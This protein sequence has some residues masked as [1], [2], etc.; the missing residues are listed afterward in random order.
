MASLIPHFVGDGRQTIENNQRRQHLII[1]IGISKIFSIACHET[2]SCQNIFKNLHSNSV[3][4][5]MLWFIKKIF[6]T[7]N[8]V[9]AQRKR[10]GLITRRTVDR[11]HPTINC[12][13]EHRF[14]SRMAVFFHG[15][16]N[17]IGKYIYI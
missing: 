6:S 17:I 2:S 16:T 11:N 3:F 10:V 8:I 7:M 14:K 9:V 12:H 13:V 4:L 5:F 1:K 15:N